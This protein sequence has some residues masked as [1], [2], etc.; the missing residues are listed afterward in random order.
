ML[1]MRRLLAMLLLAFLIVVPMSATAKRSEYC[2]S[3]TVSYYGTPITVGPVCVP[4]SGKVCS[5]LPT[6]LPGLCGMPS[7]VQAGYG[8]ESR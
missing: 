2:A 3:V 7:A 5:K 6:C 4:C 8:A 1:T